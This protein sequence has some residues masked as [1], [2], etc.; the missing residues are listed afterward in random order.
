MTNMLEKIYDSFLEL[1]LIRLRL[2]ELLA[3]QEPA[4]PGADAV[5]RAVKSA[6]T[7]FMIV[8]IG[9]GVAQDNGGQGV[10][11]LAGH[12]PKDLHAILA[13]ASVNKHGFARGESEEHRVPI[14]RVEEPASQ[15]IQGRQIVIDPILLSAVIH[16]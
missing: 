8:M 6:T 14:S 16:G 15:H 3:Q 9:I 4:I 10:Y 1:I 12:M 5:D 11:P 2:P 13:A 7:V